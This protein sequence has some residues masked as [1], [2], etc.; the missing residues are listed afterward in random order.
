MSEQIV[1]EELRKQLKAYQKELIYDVVSY[2]I[3]VFL[4]IKA[5][6]IHNTYPLDDDNPEGSKYYIPNYQRAFVWGEVA[7]SRLIESIMLGL[8]IQP[9]FLHEQENGCFEIVDGSQR[10]RSI[11]TFCENTEFK[12]L[13][14][15]K[16]KNL[17]G[18]GYTDLPRDIKNSYFLNRTLQLVRLNKE[19]PEDVRRDVFNRL[20][21]TGEKLK[22]AEARKGTFGAFYEFLV[23]LSQNERF[24]KLTGLESNFE[25]K[26]TRGVE[27][28]LVTRFFAYHED[29]AIFKHDVRP[30]LDDYVDRYDQQFETL[31][32]A[33][34]ENLKQQ[35]RHKFEKMLDFVE[36]HFEYGFC[37][38]PGKN[39]KISSTPRVR[40]EA[41]AIGV[42]EALERNP[43]LAKIPQGKLDTSWV[44]EDKAFKKVTTAD[45][46]NSKPRLNARIE[47]VRDKLLATIEASAQ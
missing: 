24:L 34:I 29:R 30:F 38:K 4:G 31:N 47:F 1:I 25:M 42:L 10:M 26:K 23:E 17:N 33:K 41:I 21:T 44:N 6:N 18:M 12:L 37:K 16:L 15:E 22:D 3:E 11:F 35:F 45:G 5:L 7:I 32:Q 8:P 9:I 27:H 39:K 43:K 46:S 13:G 40:F 14:L 2:P 36:T 19:T 20:N 28:E